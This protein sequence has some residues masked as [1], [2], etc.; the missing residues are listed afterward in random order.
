M[1]INTTIKEDEYVPRE[2]WGRD[3]WSTL[4]YIETKLVDGNGYRVQFDP[5]MRQNRRHFRVLAG[6]KSEGIPM[7]PEHGT[8]L[9]D[10]TYLP[11]HD[12]WCC[13]QDMLK[14]GLFTGDPNKWDSGFEL[15]L[16]E[17]GHKAIAAVRKH[18]A[19]GGSFATCGPLVEV[20]LA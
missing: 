14:A 5:R 20:A 3:H 6:R 9:S 18:K 17:A 19:Q 11:W 8:S 7:S 4:A 2:L 12:D 13:V 16:S 15:R 10:D 1:N